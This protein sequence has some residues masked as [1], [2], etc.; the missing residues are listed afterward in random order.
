VHDQ[1]ARH[2]VPGKRSLPG[3]QM[4]AFLLCP[5][6]RDRERKK[7]RERELYGFDIT[8][9]KDTNSMGSGP[10]FYEFI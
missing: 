3:L 9:Y 4:A 5:L 7:E 1:G 10:Q 2:L 8:L 6:F